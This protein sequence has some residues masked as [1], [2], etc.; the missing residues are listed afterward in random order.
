MPTIFIR[1]L[2]ERLARRWLLERYGEPCGRGMNPE[3]LVDYQRK[4]KDCIIC[5]KWRQF[6]ELF[7]ESGW[8]EVYMENC[9]HD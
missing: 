2:A 7:D 6:R 5:I 3:R 9:N 4:H 1:A 8:Q